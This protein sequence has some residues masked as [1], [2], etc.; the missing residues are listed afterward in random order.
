MSAWRDLV[1]ASLIGTERA[2]VPA[3]PIPFAPTRPGAPDNPFP[4]RPVPDAP[5]DPASA[6]LDRA[7]L[8]T[9]ARRG[10]LRPERAEPL[11]AAGPDMAPAVSRAAGRRLAR[12]LSGEHA[13]LLTEW[14]AAVADR[15][16]RVPARWL[17]ALLHQARR[18]T[19]ADSGLRLLVATTGGPRARWLA[20]LNP[21]WKF[22]LAYAPAGEDAWRLG[23]AAERRGY[24]S[25]LRARDPGA[26]RDLVAQGWDAAGP[27]ERAM[28]LGVIADGLSPA[29][30]PLLDGALDDRNARVRQ[31][32]ADLLAALPRSALAERMAIRAVDCL[33]L[34][35]GI[36]GVRLVVSPPGECDAALRRDGVAPGHGTG[37]AELAS[38][39]HLLLEVVARTPLRIWTDGFGMTG[40]PR[41]STCRQA[42][43]RRRYSPAGRER[44]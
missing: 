21:E 29:D 17:P 11:T 8:L 35:R 20:G 23:G 39:S 13:D 10:G 36:R 5:A 31:A 3:V 4:E 34:N 41:S 38:R 6:L 18:V 7:A 30:E 28:F 14:L 26:A 1:T 15:G 24:L 16:R 27:D 12:M 32:A 9:A 25:A 37:A 22:V 44:P 33:R 40:R 19:P 43:G 2:A 42:A